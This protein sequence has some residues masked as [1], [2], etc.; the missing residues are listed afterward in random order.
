M[1]SNSIRPRSRKMF[2]DVLRVSPRALNRSRWVPPASAHRLHETVA[3]RRL[4]P[5]L[6]TRL[7]RLPMTLFLPMGCKQG[8]TI[9]VTPP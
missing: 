8:Y 1:Y 6:L 4:P 9:E 5:A 7:L 3:Y 2:Q